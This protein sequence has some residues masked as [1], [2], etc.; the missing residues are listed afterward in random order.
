MKLKCCEGN[1]QPGA[2]ILSLAILVA[3]DDTLYHC[4]TFPCRLRRKN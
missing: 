2:A 4:R 1:R 3:G